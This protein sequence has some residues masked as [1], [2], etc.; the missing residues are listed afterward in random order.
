LLLPDLLAVVFNDRLINASMRKTAPSMED[1]VAAYTKRHH[2]PPRTLILSETAGTFGHA[3]VTS[4]LVKRIKSIGGEVIVVSGNHSENIFDFGGSIRRIPPIVLDSGSG[5]AW[6][7]AGQPYE[8]DAAY[9]NQRKEAILDISREF[10]PDI[11]VFEF[12]PLARYPCRD[13]DLE[14][15]VQ[16][17]KEVSTRVPFVSIARDSST[18][19]D[20]KRELLRQFD[21]VLIRGWK[22]IVWG[23]G[24]DTIQKLAEIVPKPEYLGHILADTPS[25]DR[26]GSPHES[27]VIVFASGGYQECDEIFFQKAIESRQHSNFAHQPWRVVVS[28]EC[29]DDVF[30]A[31]KDK[32]KAENQAA[33]RMPGEITVVRPYRND[34]FSK[35]LTACCA[36]I[37]RGSYNA[38]LELAVRKKPFVVV[39]LSGS[40]FEWEHL[41]RAEFLEREKICTKITEPEI[42]GDDGARLLALKLDKSSILP[43][44]RNLEFQDGSQFAVRLIQIAVQPR[45]NTL[46]DRLAKQTKRSVRNLLPMERRVQ[47][48]G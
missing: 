8:E 26:S 18:V 13:V 24:K 19:N 32:A 46:A 4:T 33:Q 45:L 22:G 10:K 31:L 1:R 9:Q 35:D 48:I 21:Y 40:G 44:A 42:A 36:A 43:G 28:T 38:T 15:L 41:S 11:V 37:V 47:R 39:P 20:K 6:T 34:D 3:N 14:A 16:Y 23:N 27:S 5:K 29:P 12:Y 17:R 2:H 7:P 25:I 30:R